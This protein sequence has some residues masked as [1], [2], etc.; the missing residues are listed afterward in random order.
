MMVSDVSAGGITVIERVAVPV[1]PAASVA[2]QVTIVVPMG[3]VAPYLIQSEMVVV[4]PPHV[5]CPSSTPV[6]EEQIEPETLSDTS[7]AK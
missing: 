6:A 5:V 4:P 2:V 1:F 3:N 7:T